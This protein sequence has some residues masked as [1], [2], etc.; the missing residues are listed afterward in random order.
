MTSLEISIDIAGT[1][2]AVS[3]LVV[4]IS[5]WRRVRTVERELRPLRRAYS[6]SLGARAQE[7]TRYLR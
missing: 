1:L 6:A 5:V 2:T 4:A 7:K 3:S